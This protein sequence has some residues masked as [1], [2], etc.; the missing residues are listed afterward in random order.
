MGVYLAVAKQSFRRQSTYRAAMV[1]GIFTNAVF[2]VILA[3]VL[4][5]AFESQPE[6]NGLDASAAVT[7][8]FI[9][10]GMLL[11]T[12]AFGWHELSD[13]VRTGDIATDLQRP[14]DVSLYWMAMFVGASAFSAVGRGVPPFL[15]GGLVF[16]LRLPDSVAT[17]IG[18]AATVAGAAAVASRWWFLVSLSSFWFIGDIKGLVSLASGLQL[19]CSGTIVPLQFFPDALGELLRRTPFAAM[20]QLPAE[21][22]L[23]L[24]GAGPVLGAQAGW[25]LALHACGLV[26]LRRAARKLV[27]EG[28]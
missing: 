16:D 9:T 26:V 13:R 21:V 12:T 7:I 20:A 10:Q 4:L 1:A 8:T 11:I 15:L 3:S 23:G 14:V 2:G 17:W 22:F 25:A 19:F 24:Q 27:I 28:G 6:I 18:F 5:A